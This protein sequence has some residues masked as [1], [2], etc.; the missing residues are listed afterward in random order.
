V[1][2]QTVNKSVKPGRRWDIDWLRVLAVLLLFYVH[3]ARIFYVWDP[4]YVQNNQLSLTLSRLAVFINHWHM[5]LFFILAG[6]ATW[7]SLRRRSG[8]Q[9]SRERLKRLLVPFIFGF[10]VIVPPQ[11]YLGLQKDPG[12]AESYLRFYPRF[13]SYADMGHLWFILYL[14]LFSLVAL[15]LFLYFKR[16]SGGRLIERLAG[17]L[18][19]PGMI[20]L[21]VVLLIVTDYLLLHFYPNPVYFITF[22]IYGYIMMADA[23]FE[24]TID[25]HKGVALILGLVLFVV[26]L[27]LVSLGVIGPDWLQ[28]IPRSFITWFCLIALLGYGKKL[29]NFTNSFL[30]YFGEASYPVYILHQ[31]VIVAIGFF[32]VQWDA[33]VLVKFITIVAASFVATM[34]LYDLVVKRTNVTRFLFG[35]RP[36]KKKSPEAPAARPKAA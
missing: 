20:F 2:T 24:E 11:I 15:P 22:F 7:F 4:W 17:F 8:G 35:M 5:P 14:F 29:L 13:F 10:L 12:Y 34:I 30:G 32:V 36:L 33:G 26:W 31:T 16:D 25:R 21:P 6:A 18:A 1:N 9:Y 3:P 23:R 27:S 28:P 19:R